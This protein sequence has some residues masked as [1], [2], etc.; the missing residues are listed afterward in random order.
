MRTFIFAASLAGATALFAGCERAQQTAEVS[1]QVWAADQ[2]GNAVYVLDREGTVLNTLDLAALVGADRPHT[3]HTGASGDVVFSANTVSN[4]A[5]VHRAA[6]GAVT[7]IVEGVGKAPHAVQPH[8]SDPTRAYVCN[9]APRGTDASGN[10]DLG[11]T[12][13]EL[14]RSA[15]GSWTI[16]RTLDLRAESVLADTTLFPSRRPVLVGFTADGE[17]MLVTLFNGGVGVVDLASWTVVNAWGADQVHQHATVLAASPDANEMY[18]TAGDENGS[19]LYVFEVAAEPAL[20]ASHDLSAWG[21]DAHGVA[22]DRVRNE[23]WLTHRA[24]GNLTIHPLASI[25]DA[26]TPTVVDM[27]GETPDLI[28]IA[29]DGERAY[30][31]LRGPNPAPTIPFPLT[32]NQPGIAVIDVPGRAVMKIVPLGDPDAGDFHGVALVGT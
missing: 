13:T 18:V 2:N 23:L 30:V 29:P 4:Q 6:D 22:V 15:D 24:S 20:V 17:Q 12:I 3:I 14:A 10:P 21:R 32:G 28:E 19:W 5:S 9:I 7:S 27:G 1:Y 11:E 31:T 8:P 25:R 26:H 16:A